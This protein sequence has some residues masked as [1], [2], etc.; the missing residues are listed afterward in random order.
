M[1]SRP[2]R[3]WGAAVIALALVAACGDPVTPPDEGEFAG[4]WAGRPWL[5]D[6]GGLLLRGAPEGDVLHVWGQN[7][8][9][10]EPWGVRESISA[11]VIFHGTGAYQLGPSDVSFTELVGGDGIVARYGGAGSPSGTLRITRYDPETRTIE[12]ELD[13]AA[14]TSSPL[15]SYGTAARLEEGRFR[16][17]IDVRSSP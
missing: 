10:A 8:R 13:F 15:A 5:G 2:S 17:A 16:A 3:F 14:T 7:P 1:M 12:G 6:A 9:G 11:R 4:L